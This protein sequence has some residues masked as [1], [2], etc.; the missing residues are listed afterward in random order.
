VSDAE[1]RRDVQQCLSCCFRDATLNER[2]LEALLPGANPPD[3]EEIEYMRARRWGAGAL[4]GADG[5]A[6]AAYGEPDDRAAGSVSI[7]RTG[8]ARTARGS[9]GFTTAARSRHRGCRHGSLGCADTLQARGVTRC[10][11]TL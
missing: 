2:L 6:T 4:A 11:E 8:A 5:D 1:Q 9:H 10:Q 3:A 7:S